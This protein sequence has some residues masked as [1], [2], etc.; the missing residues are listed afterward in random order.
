MNSVSLH[1]NASLSINSVKYSAGQLSVY[2]DYSQDIVGYPATLTF[3]LD[4]S[5][6]KV[7]SI[8]TNFTIIQSDG[9]QFGSS[10]NASAL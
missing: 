7:S 5:I 1:S 8:S 10:S 6:Y 2:V 9:V 3:N 4:P